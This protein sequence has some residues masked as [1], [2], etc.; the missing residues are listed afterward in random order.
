MASTQA[1]VNG[2]VDV[3][4]SAGSCFVCA[5]DSPN[6]LMRASK[7]EYGEATG[8]WSASDAIGF[9]R[10]FS[11]PSELAARAGGGGG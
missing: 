10:V 4:L 3:R 11:L 6:S 2:W 1:R 5:S 7:G 9:A 8:E